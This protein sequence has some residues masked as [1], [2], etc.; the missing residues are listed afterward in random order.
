MEL[1]YLAKPA[2]GGWVSFTAHLA[3][4]HDL[5]VFKLGNRTEDTKRPFGYGV[6]YQNRSAADVRNVEKKVLITAIDKN[7]YEDLKHFPDDTFVVIH[8]PCEVTKKTSSIL[9][10]QLPRFRIITIRT[11][12]QTYLKEVFHLDSLFLRHPFF[13]YKYTKDPRPEKAVSI[14]RIDFDKHTEILL[15][16]NQKLPKSK[17]IE[18]HGSL[19][20]MFV[21]FKLKGLPFKE[22]YKGQFP[23]SFEALTDILKGA[24]YCLDM[25]VIKH[26]GGGTQYTFLEAI[27]QECALVINKKWVDGFETPFQDGKN[28]F[29]VESGEELATLL[30]QDPSV[31]TILK[32]AKHILEPHIAVDW[33]AALQEKKI[34]KIWK[35]QK[36]TKK[37]NL[38][39]KTA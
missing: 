16:A 30:K 20:R 4:K 3:L 6:D 8:D 5:P 17:Q 18:I 34:K 19:N 37:R 11:S 9:L 31:K 26:D 22:A 33:M 27:Y 14:S 23:K 28:C 35:T 13:P 25:S 1:Y 2:Y 39:R 10:E 24:K 12:V 7:F 32:E 21:Y 15:E 36:R 38:T 29:V